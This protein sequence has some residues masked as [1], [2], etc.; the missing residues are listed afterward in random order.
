ML[1]ACQIHV[2]L[3]VIEI[4]VFKCLIRWFQFKHICIAAK[5]GGGSRSYVCER[6]LLFFFF[7]KHNDLT[8]PRCR[9]TRL[10]A[11]RDFRHNACTETFCT[12]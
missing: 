9:V 12:S 11:A 1:Q 10:T 8:S 5:G 2:T 3:N 6:Q 7:F 4:D